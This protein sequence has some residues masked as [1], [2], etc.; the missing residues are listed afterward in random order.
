MFNKNKNE[1]PEPTKLEKALN[2]AYDALLAQ[3]LSG[4]EYLATLEKLER[5]HKLAPP[6][7]EVKPVSMDAVIAVAGNLAGI[8]MILSH[9]RVAVIGTKALGMVIKPR[10]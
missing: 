9:E 10:M 3:D 6:T 1:T 8:V 4:P 7:A 2:A 5:L